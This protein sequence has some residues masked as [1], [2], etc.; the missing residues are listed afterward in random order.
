ME[1]YGKRLSSPGCYRATAALKREPENGEAAF[2]RG[3]A[4]ARVGEYMKAIQ[5]FGHVQPDC[6]KSADAKVYK[7]A[8]G[9]L[10]LDIDTAPFQEKVKLRTA[11]DLIIASVRA[12]GFELNF[13]VDRDSFLEGTA[14]LGDPLEDE[15]NAPPLLNAGFARNP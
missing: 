12:K 7:A 9:A 14:D 4:F 1:P 3:V 11:L 15:V 5:D 13:L 2:Y 8:A 6:V 10:I